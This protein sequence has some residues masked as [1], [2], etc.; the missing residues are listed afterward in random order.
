MSLFSLLFPDL[1]R[2]KFQREFITFD[3]RVS[4]AHASKNP[5]DPSRIGASR[6]FR[7]VLFRAHCFIHLLFTGSEVT[8]STVTKSLGTL[9]A[10]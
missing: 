9:S 1:P 4:L 10:F 2:R 6:A 8:P 3:R 5:A 7:K